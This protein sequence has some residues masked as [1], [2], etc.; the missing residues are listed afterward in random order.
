MREYKA[1][2]FGPVEVRGQ[3]KL[4]FPFTFLFPGGNLN[5]DIK[6]NTSCPSNSIKQSLHTQF[7]QIRVANIFYHFRESISLDYVHIQTFTYELITDKIVYQVRTSS[8]E[9]YIMRMDFLFIVLFPIYHGQRLQ[10]LR[11]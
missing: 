10:V 6:Q 11:E 1:E 4:L 7:V 3:Y 5:N 2:H 9:D 8:P